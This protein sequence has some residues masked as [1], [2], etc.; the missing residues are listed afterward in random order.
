[1]AMRYSVAMRQSLATIANQRRSPRALAPRL[2]LAAIATPHLLFAA[3][4]CVDPPEEAATV[5][6]DTVSN[7]QPY[8]NSLGAVATYDSAA[9][10]DL[11]GPFFP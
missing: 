10:I 1:M 2:A 5:L 3:S 7:D 6:S 4:G 8:A 11:G 9:A